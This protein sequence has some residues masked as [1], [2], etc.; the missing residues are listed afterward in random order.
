MRSRVRGNRGGWVRDEWRR[1][2]SGRGRWCNGS[3]CVRSH[4]P[5][6]GRDVFDQNKS[7][8]LGR[9][10][11]C[12]DRTS[13]RW[14]IRSRST[15]TEGTNSLVRLPQGLTPTTGPSRFI[16]HGNWCKVRVLSGDVFEENIQG[17]ISIP[18]VSSLS[19]SLMGLTVSV[20]R[21]YPTGRDLGL[22]T[23][24]TD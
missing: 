8:I 19:G 14:G 5:R 1:F 11:V 17:K 7:P 20:L 3:C 24:S 18:S 4:R 15:P 10:P 13:T 2:G 21:V 6:V 23:S 22:E 9:D 12:R 16:D